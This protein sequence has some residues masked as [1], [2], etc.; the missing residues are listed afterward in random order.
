[1]RAGPCAFISSSSTKSATTEIQPSSQ[2]V[3]P[4]GPPLGVTRKPRREVPLPSQEKKEGA[5][6]YALYVP[7]LSLFFAFRTIRTIILGSH[8]HTHTYHIL[9]PSPPKCAFTEC[10][11][12]SLTLPQPTQNNTRSS[13]QLGPP[14]LPLAHDLWPRLLRCRNDAPL[15]PALRPRQTRNNFPRIPSPIGRDDCSGHAHKQDGSC[16][17]PSVRPNAG[18]ALGDFDG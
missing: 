1:M 11:P 16:T 15:H 10:N 2:N 18:P 6:Q 14:G 7:P 4:G 8:A 12:I 5:M 13:R 3:Q 9:L 17:T